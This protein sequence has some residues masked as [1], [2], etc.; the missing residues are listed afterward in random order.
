[1]KC[2]SLLTE[3]PKNVDKDHLKVYLSQLFTLKTILA[4]NSNE[5][6][7]QRNYLIIL[8]H[9]LHHSILLPNVK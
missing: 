1:M 2:L 7:L 3:N 4:N 9:I 6:S 5:K 8:N